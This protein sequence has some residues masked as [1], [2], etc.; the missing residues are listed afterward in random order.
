M[1]SNI[2]Q[3]LGTN[4]VHP[5]L[6]RSTMSHTVTALS[7]GTSSPEPQYSNF[8]DNAPTWEVLADM[9]RAKREELNI[10]EPDLEAV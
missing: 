2:Q 1:L 9:V 3:L 7:Q 10:P 6:L 8:A 5:R 4:K